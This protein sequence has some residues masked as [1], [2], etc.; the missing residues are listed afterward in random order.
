MEENPKRKKLVALGLLVAFAVLI[1]V[2]FL[3][4][5]GKF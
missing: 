1:L 4:Q 3:Q 5:A 2:V